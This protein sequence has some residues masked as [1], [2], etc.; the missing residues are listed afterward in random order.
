[1]CG[2]VL[3][4][5]DPAIVQALRRLA[6]RKGVSAEELVTDW[7]RAQ[8]VAPEGGGIDWEAMDRLLREVDAMPRVGTFSDDDLYGPDGLPK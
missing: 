8:D 5:D 3:V 4:I 7:V 1:M 2:D 6:L